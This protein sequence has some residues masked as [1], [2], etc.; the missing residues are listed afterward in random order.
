MST[1]TRESYTVDYAGFW[2]RLGAFLVDG[3][4][5]WGINYLMT[6]IW[7]I[8]T[9][10][11]WAGLSDQLGD[12]GF[13]TTPQWAAR[14]LVFFVVIV[15]YF[16]CLWAWRGQTPGKMV[17]RLKITRFDGA[18]IGWGGAFLRLCGYIISG[19]ILMIGFLWV[20]FDS[21]RQGVHDKIAETFVVRIP[22]RKEQAAWRSTIDSRSI[23]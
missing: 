7:N 3:G 20:A 8:A 6:G 11:P 17:F 2:L 13:G 12:E 9:G 22:T 21:R 10:L 5:L 4:V 14:V 23:H 18:A 1:T 15:A 19:F 16:V